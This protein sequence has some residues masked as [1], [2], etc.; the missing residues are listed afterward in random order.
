MRFLPGDSSPET[1]AAKSWSS[2]RAASLHPVLGFCAVATI[3]LPAHPSLQSVLIAFGV[4][5]PVI[6]ILFTVPVLY[7]VMRICVFSDRNL[8]IMF[9]FFALI[10]WLILRSIGSPALGQDNNLESIRGV[11]VLMP[12]ALSCALVGARCS[13]YSARTIAILGF[14][15]LSHYCLAL[16]ADGSFPESTGFRSLSAD[17]DRHSYQSTSFYIGL[18]GIAMMSLGCRGKGCDAVYGLGGGC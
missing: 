10:T 18:V 15:A 7:G 8:A 12:L 2:D 9:P 17:A 4:A 6:A 5:S 1:L 16:F 13:P 11:L 3:L 14:L